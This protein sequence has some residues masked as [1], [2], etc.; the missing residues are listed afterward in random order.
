LPFFAGMKKTSSK[1]SLSRSTL[2]RLDGRD[3]ARVGGGLITDTEITDTSSGSTTGSG[4]GTSLCS[5]PT[6]NGP[7]LPS[8]GFSCGSACGACG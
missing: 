8:L 3:L 7:C 6:F 4:G 5:G 2:R 1:L